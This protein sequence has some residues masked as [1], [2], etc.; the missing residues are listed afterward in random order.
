M[1]LTALLKVHKGE[2]FHPYR[3][4]L[5]GGRVLEI[6]RPERLSIHP[7]GK[8]VTV[9]STGPFRDSGL[10]VVVGEE[11]IALADIARIDVVFGGRDRRRAIIDDLRSYQQADPFVPFR[12][13][14]GHETFLVADAE[15]IELAPDGGYVRLAITDGYSLIDALDVIAVEPMG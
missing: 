5:K 4:T 12:F 2:E 6:D 13:R 1:V 10:E 8:S 11:E 9:I 14:T 7:G 3:L 15:T